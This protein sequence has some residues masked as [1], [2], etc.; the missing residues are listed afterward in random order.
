MIYGVAAWPTL[1]DNQSPVATKASSSRTI[2]S[3]LSDTEHI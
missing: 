2:A 1:S 3:F